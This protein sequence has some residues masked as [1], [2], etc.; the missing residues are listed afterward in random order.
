MLF[1]IVESFS[2]SY[3]KKKGQEGCWI[4]TNPEYSS[5]F[6]APPRDNNSENVFLQTPAP[7]REKITENHLKLLMTY[8]FE[9]W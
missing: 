1:A 5:A 7:A 2:C 8:S 4:L 3:L 6:S 9:T